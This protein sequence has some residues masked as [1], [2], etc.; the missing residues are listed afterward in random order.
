MAKS[1][2]VVEGVYVTPTGI[3]FGSKGKV[4]PASVALASIPNKGERRKL[5]KAFHSVGR[6]DL[7]SARVG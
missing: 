4:L 5:R 1:I 6:V 3:K 7:A 2:K